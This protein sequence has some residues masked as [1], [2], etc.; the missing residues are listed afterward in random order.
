MQA[1]IRAV[2]AILAVLLLALIA[3]VSVPSAA[4]ASTT[5]SCSTGGVSYMTNKMWVTQTY[6]GGSV[7]WK[8]RVERTPNRTT[9]YNGSTPIDHRG[10]KYSQ[11]ANGA[12]RK[13]AT[14]PPTVF[15]YYSVF[16][17]GTH[18]T[19]WTVTP[20]GANPQYHSCAVTF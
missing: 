12:T 11:F 3:L 19:F 17:S 2:R 1:M 15:T 6:V 14:P 10:T 16:G 13:T 9:W 7:P 8:Y 18:R 4:N 20:S 5:K